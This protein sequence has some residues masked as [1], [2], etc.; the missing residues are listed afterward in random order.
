VN[1]N[2]VRTEPDTGPMTS[3]EILD[4]LD[5]LRPAWHGDAE[6]RGRTDV[7]FPR[8][9]HG[10]AADWGL[11]QLLCS[12]CVVR[13]QCAEAGRNEHHGMWGGI[14]R[15]TSSRLNRWHRERNRFWGIIQT[16]GPWLT[17][18][19]LEVLSGNTVRTVNRHLKALSDRGWVVSRLADDGVTR[20]WS[21]V[22]L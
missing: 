15:D 11:A 7:M 17:R 1:P 8:P 10:R 4:L 12:R 9:G 5:A 14:A 19:R 16:H 13:R 2:D 6:C 21:A 18:Q 22:E 20:E 3:E